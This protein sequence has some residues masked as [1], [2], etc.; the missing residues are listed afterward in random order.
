[1]SY[2]AGA[3]CLLLAV[4]PA[5]IGIVAREADWVMALNN[6]RH[7]VCGKEQMN[8]LV[9]ITEHI[10][11]NTTIPPSDILPYTIKYLT[12]HA[13]GV[14]GLGAVSAA[15]MSSSDG[16]IL[17][18]SSMFTQNIIKMAIYPRA[19][20]RVGATMCQLAWTSSCSY[21]HYDCQSSLLARWP[22]ISRSW[23]TVFMHCGI[24]VVTLCT[25]LYFPI[26]S[27]YYL[28]P[29]AMRMAC[30]VGRPMGMCYHLSDRFGSFMNS[31][32]IL[33]ATKIRETR[34]SETFCN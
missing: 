13:V 16:S 20:Q 21:G 6:T 31:L 5:L 29:C 19:S 3:G 18:A 4:P 7:A 1:M 28:C 27:P 15:V 11:Q 10:V 26:L 34:E 2:T 14:L 32:T 8:L 25:S 23:P 12:P 17:S 24:C 22:A 30:C 33:V 9:G